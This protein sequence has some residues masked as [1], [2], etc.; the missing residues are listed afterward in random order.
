MDIT[1]LPEFEKDLKHL[2]KKYRTLTDDLENVKAILKK[3]PNEHPPF[4]FQIDNLSINT[5]IIKV[6]SSLIDFRKKFI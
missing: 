2:L 1:H 4:S 6:Y 3:R 5:C